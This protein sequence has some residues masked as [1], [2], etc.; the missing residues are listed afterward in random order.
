METTEKTK[1]DTIE[2]PKKNNTNKIVII[3]L[4]V[5]VLALA[6]LLIVTKTKMNTI[7]LKQDKA[8]TK[9]Q[10]LQRQLDSLVTEHNKI[11][12]AYGSLSGKLAARDSDIRKKA[13]EIQKL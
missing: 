3:I 9:N 1:V 4:S 13:D 8:E 5:V 10:Q 6:G 11:K 7:V 12:E 2:E